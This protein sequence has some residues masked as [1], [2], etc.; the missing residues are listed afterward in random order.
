MIAANHMYNAA[1]KDGTV[2]GDISGP[3]V[4][5]QLFGDPGGAIRMGKLPLSRRPE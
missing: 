5:E 4:L 3:I 1:P 2:I